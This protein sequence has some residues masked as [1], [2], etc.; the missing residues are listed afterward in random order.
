[1][2]NFGRSRVEVA[3]ILTSR[4]LGVVSPF[5]RARGRPRPKP[6][7]EALKLYCTIWHHRDPE[8]QT[9]EEDAQRIRS[10][11]ETLAGP[12]IQ[13]MSPDEAESLALRLIRDANVSV[14]EDGAP[15]QEPMSDVV[16][17]EEQRLIA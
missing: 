7:R 1:M 9:P 10:V 3:H 2:A 17:E 5:D 15:G 12:E 14:L 6:I 8:S 4:M 16:T 11:I 13:N